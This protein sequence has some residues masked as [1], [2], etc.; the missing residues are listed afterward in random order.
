MVR[1]CTMIAHIVLFV[2]GVSQDGKC[3]VGCL[4]NNIVTGFVDFE[5]DNLNET[6]LFKLMQFK[7]Q[8]NIGFIGRCFTCF[9]Y[10]NKIYWILEKIQNYKC[11]YDR[12]FLR[13]AF[14]IHKC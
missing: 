11:L 10:G 4:R 3:G 14:R 13:K 7:Q 1:I 6:T 8:R 5:T 9:F 12:V 2:Y